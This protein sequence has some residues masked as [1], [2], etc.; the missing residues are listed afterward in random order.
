[1]IDYGRGVTNIDM[2]TG[3]RY[4]VIALNNLSSDAVVENL[5]PEYPFNCP[6]CGN[7]TL[8]PSRSARY[9]YYCQTCKTWHNSED[10]YGEDSIGCHLEDD[11]YTLVDCLDNDLMIIKSLHFT[12]A[13]FCSPCVPGAGNLDSPDEEGGVM[14]YC[15]G[16]EWF[17]E[18]SPCPYKIHHVSELQ[19]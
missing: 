9:E 18:Y 17:D 10:C 1:M 2:K 5:E 8:V 11:E 7:E 15:L 12:F 13:Q 19:D 14:A 16:P 6:Q 3:I 4:G